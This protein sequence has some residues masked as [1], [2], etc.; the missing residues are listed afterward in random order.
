MVR[1]VARLRALLI[2]SFLSVT[3]MSLCWC[4]TRSADQNGAKSPGMSEAS[5]SEVGKSRLSKD[6]RSER[7][8]YIL[9][10]IA[11]DGNA[12]P[13]VQRRAEIALKRWKGPIG[14]DTS[15][16]FLVR[17]MLYDAYSGGRY[18]WLNPIAIDQN[19]PDLCGVRIKEER[20]NPDGSRAVI[21]EDYPV[22]V[23]YFDAPLDGGLSTAVHIRTG[24]EQKDVKLWEEY[25]IDNIDRLIYEHIAKQGPRKRRSLAMPPVWIS[26][27]DPNKVRVFIS[28]YDRARNRSEYVQLE[29]LRDP[30]YEETVSKYSNLDQPGFYWTEIWMRQHRG[31]TGTGTN[32]R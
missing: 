2:C 25:L 7:I 8:S 30:K 6:W 27:P 20:I 3:F 9:H 5:P 24:D 4:R 11:E 1:M 22:Y 28:V 10:E 31:K 13:D 17:A 19:L 14:L 21:E 29:D 18:A 32:F 26:T 12:P 15:K 23:G 16:P